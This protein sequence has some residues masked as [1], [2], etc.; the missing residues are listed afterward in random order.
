ME[1][2]SPRVQRDLISGGIFTLVRG[3]DKWLMRYMCQCNKNH[4]PLKWKY[5][6]SHR[7]HQQLFSFSGLAATASGLGHN[8]RRALGQQRMDARFVWRRSPCG[9]PPGDSATLLVQR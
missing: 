5:D 7:Q 2:G 6:N 8:C 1:S 9:R 3:Q 4:K